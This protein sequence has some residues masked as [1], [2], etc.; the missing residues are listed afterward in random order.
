MVANGGLHLAELL[1]GYHCRGYSLHGEPQYKG[2]HDRPAS[3][4]AQC[5]FYDQRRFGY[6]CSYGQ[7]DG[8]RPAADRQIVLTQSDSRWWH[9]DA[10]FHHHESEHERRADQ[11]WIYGLLPERRGGCVDSRGIDDQLRF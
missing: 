2:H 1:R 10:Y 11:R 7:S 9:I 5:R 4:R 6:D 3:A 8:A